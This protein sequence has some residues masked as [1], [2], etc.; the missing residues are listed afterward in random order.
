MDHAEL[1]R[2]FWEILLVEVEEIGCFERVI[3]S[4]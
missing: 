3:A 4:D 1:G 2:R